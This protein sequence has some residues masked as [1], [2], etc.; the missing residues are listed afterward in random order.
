M[1]SVLHILFKQYRTQYYKW[2]TQW[3]NPENVS[4]GKS[5]SG[6]C[7]LHN[8]KPQREVKPHTA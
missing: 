4:I 3:E 5:Y 1:T 8:A 7:V 2:K 6:Q